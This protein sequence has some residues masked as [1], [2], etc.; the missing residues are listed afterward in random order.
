M[1]ATL[2]MPHSTVTDGAAFG[3]FAKSDQDGS[4]MMSQQELCAVFKA[5]N[6]EALPLGTSRAR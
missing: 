1:R 5:F 3:P 4:G 2:I 6:P